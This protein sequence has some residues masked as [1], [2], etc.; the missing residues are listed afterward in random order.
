MHCDDTKAFEN[1]TNKCYDNLALDHHGEYVYI[2][3]SRVNLNLAQERNP[4]VRFSATREHGTQT[5]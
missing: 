2:A 3:A 4:L 1:F 5:N